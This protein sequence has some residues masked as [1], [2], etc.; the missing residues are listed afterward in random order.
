VSYQFGGLNLSAQLMH[1]VHTK[2]AMGGGIFN[3]RLLVP[4]Q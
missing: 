2:N 1:D 3:V 4:F